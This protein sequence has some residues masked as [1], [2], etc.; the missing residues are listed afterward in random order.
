[1]AVL[2]PGRNT[3]RAFG[4]QMNGNVVHEVELTDQAGQPWLLSDALGQGALVLVFYRG[5]W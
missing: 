5:D 2:S 1:M 3:T 4:S